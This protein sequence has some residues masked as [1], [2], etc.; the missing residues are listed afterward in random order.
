MPK[1][2]P[3]EFYVAIVALIMVLDSW[4]FGGFEKIF[5]WSL[6]IITRH[7]HQ[8]ETQVTEGV[9]W[10]PYCQG[11]R[12]WGGYSFLVKTRADDQCHQLPKF[13]PEKPGHK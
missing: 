10:K 11:C 4:F 7:R 5:S 9:W 3:A 2:L 13:F 8:W 12:E 6:W 1:S